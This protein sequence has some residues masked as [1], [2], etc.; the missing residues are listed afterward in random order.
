MDRCKQC[1]TDTTYSTSL[2]NFNSYITH[3]QLVVGILAFNNYSKHGYVVEQ[4]SLRFSS[5]TKPGCGILSR[6]CEVKTG[7]SSYV[8]SRSTQI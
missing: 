4:V 7:V 8:P 5:Q 6:M 1:G 3:M 2:N